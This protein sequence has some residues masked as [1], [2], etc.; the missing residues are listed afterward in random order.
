MCESSV[1]NYTSHQHHFS[2]TRLCPSFSISAAKIG[3][4]LQQGKGNWMNT[5]R[6]KSAPEQSQGN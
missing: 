1:V 4:L 3:T 2:K 6:A 5:S